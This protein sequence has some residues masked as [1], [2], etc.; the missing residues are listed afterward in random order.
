MTES[1]PLKTSSPFL[2][3]KYQD[4]PSCQVAVQADGAALVADALDGAD[5]SSVQ[6]FSV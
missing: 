5:G 1:R 4:K 3:E 2:K 6:S